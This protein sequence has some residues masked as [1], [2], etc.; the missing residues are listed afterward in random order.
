MKTCIFYV[1]SC[2]DIHLSISLKIVALSLA[3]V[4]KAFVEM[5]SFYSHIDVR[6]M[7]SSFLLVLK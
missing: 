5:M 2:I 3:L 6:S 4:M 1:F 7:S